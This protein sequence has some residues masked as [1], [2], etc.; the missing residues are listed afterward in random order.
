[1][2]KESGEKLKCTLAYLAGIIDGE[3]SIGIYARKSRNSRSKEYFIQVTCIM[4][5][6]QAIDLLASVFGGLHAHRVQG[7]A[8]AISFVWR[9]TSR[10][11]Y[12]CLLCLLPF[13]KIKRNQAQYAIQFNEQELNKTRAGCFGGERRLSVT[14]LDIRETYKRKM[15]E[16]KKEQYIYAQGVREEI[17]PA[18]A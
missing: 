5:E 1:M 15:S 10:K 8:G 3:G 17:A 7:H 11:A 6:R 14:E 9:V 2:P 12:N 13:L 16:M 18:R 4:R